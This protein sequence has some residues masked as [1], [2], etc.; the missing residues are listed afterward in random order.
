MRFP[1]FLFAAICALSACRSADLA[2]TDDPLAGT[3]AAVPLPPTPGQAEARSADGARAIAKANERYEFEYSY[4]AAAGTIAALRDRLDADADD[5]ERELAAAS[6]ADRAASTNAGYAFRKHS[7]S[8][9]W[10]VVADTQRFLSMSALVAIYSG[11][12]H[13][14]YTKRSLVWDRQ[15]GVAMEP[16]AFFTSPAAFRRA[17]SERYCAQLQAARQARD[18]PMPGPDGLFPVCPAL[19]DLVI[20]LGSSNGRTFDRIVLYAGPYVAGPYAEGSYE[21]VLKI[22]RTVIATVK[23]SYRDAFAQVP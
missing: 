6:A 10:K 7:L 15:G 8:V 11:G 5:L 14:D 21:Q 3:S 20:F 18:A 16:L 19:E 12:A 9:E 2:A 13:P 1:P 23:P 17:T 4:P 22:D